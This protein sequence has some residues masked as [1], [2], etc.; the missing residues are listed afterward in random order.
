MSRMRKKAGILLCVFIAAIAVC[1]VLTQ[2]FLTGEQERVYV[3]MDEASLPVVYVEAMGR[4]MN[5]LWG[6]VQEMEGTAADSLT[7]LPEDR[8]LPVRIAGY[9]GTVTGLRYEIRSLDQEQLVERTALSGWETAEGEVRASL[10]IQN[11]IS[12]DSQYQLCLVVSLDDGREARYYTRILWSSDTRAQE[13]VNLAVDFSAKTFDY[14]QAKELTTYLE[15]NPAADNSSLGHVTLQSEFDQIT[16]GGMDV[17]PLGEKRV[18]LKQLDGI[19]GNVELAYTVADSAGNYYEVTENFTMKWDA[20]RI[21]MMSYDRTMDQVFSGTADLVSGRRILLGI[22]GDSRIPVVKSGDGRYTAFVVNRDLWQFDRGSDGGRGS[23]VKVFSFRS[24][25]QTNIRNNYDCHGIKILNVDDGGNVDFLI[26]GYMNRGVHEGNVGA[27]YYRYYQDSRTLEERFF[28]PSSSTFEELALDVDRLAKLGGNGMFYIYLGGSVYAVDLNSNEYLVVASG[29]REGTYAVS[30]DQSR[31][32]WQ[33]GS[34]PYGAE[35]VHVMN[36]ETGSG[37]D[38]QAVSGEWV[39]VLGFVENDFICGMAG[40]DDLWMNGNRVL[41]LPVYRLQI[42]DDNLNVQAD[43][44]KEGI[45]VSGVQVTDGRIHLEQMVKTETGYEKTGE[46]II[47]C[48]MEVRASGASGLG[49]YASEDRKR[50]Y[51]VQLDQEVPDGA[52]IRV[53]AP[54]SVTYDMSDTL[55]LRTS[56]QRAA[57]CYRAYGNG[58]LLG[59]SENLADAIALS[60]DAM[61]YVTAENG[62]VVWDRV[63]RPNSFNIRDGAAAAGRMTRYLGSFE[64]D[65]EYSDGVRVMDVRGAGLRQVLYYVGKGCPV[66]AYEP[67]GSYR[68]ITGFDSSTVTLLNPSTGESVQMSLDEGEAYYVSRR[69]DF[70]CGLYK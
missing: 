19:M 3:S 2:N 46:D 16:W 53:S 49:W 12:R 32:A 38:I 44:E 64:E 36:L 8:L 17:Q 59:V 41:G 50:L 39:K 33:D 68:L 11:L 63:D 18:T 61:G 62:S 26:Y 35:S 6:Y 69:N 23:L 9:G 13:M 28:F 54:E 27:A 55:E 52:G 60:Y 25:D 58:K 65:T 45:Y 56:L 30:Q 34:E 66:A 70:V 1:F 14:E 20:Q 67:D 31:L 15:P 43:Y 21:Y 10:P 29:L 42:L 40:Q 24:E 22:A 57:A 4:E 47:V 48:N 7:I 5:P 51:F 37:Q